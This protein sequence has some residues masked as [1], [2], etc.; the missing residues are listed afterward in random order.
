MFQLQVVTSLL[1]PQFNRVPVV[2]YDDVIWKSIYFRRIFF[3]TLSSRE[4]FNYEK[5]FSR[6][7]IY[8]FY[9]VTK[10]PA[11]GHGLKQI[12]CLAVRDF[13]RNSTE[14]FFQTS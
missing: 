4:Q 3:Q 6:F 14:S 10:C 8:I 13:H 9:A 11:T 1:T 12:E 2:L 5:H 7:T